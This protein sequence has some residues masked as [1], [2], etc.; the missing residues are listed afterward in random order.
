MDIRGLH[1]HKIVNSE[2]K[3]QLQYKID[4][5]NVCGSRLNIALPSSSA[6]S[7]KLEIEY[8]TAPD[9]TALQWL[10]PEQTAGGKHPY[11]F[12]QCQVIFKNFFSNI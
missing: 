12:S 7:C 9:A 3:T 4:E 5:Q 2:D 11:L 8:K 1:I 6:K 10:T